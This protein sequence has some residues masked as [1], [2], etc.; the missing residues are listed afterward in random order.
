[1]YIAPEVPMMSCTFGMTLVYYWQAH[2]KDMLT[3][4]RGLLGPHTLKMHVRNSQYVLARGWAAA[5]VFVG[6]EQAES[7]TQTEVYPYH[8]YP[9]YSHRHHHLQ[10]FLPVTTTF[11]NIASNQQHWY[12]TPSPLPGTEAHPSGPPHSG[13]MTPGGVHS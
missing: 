7:V 8:I 6:F 5:S 11:Q 3:P 1:M 13:T 12:Q 2:C 4:G 10:L 9:R